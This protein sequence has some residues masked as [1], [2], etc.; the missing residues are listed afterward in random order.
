MKK[1]SI[2]LI[3]ITAF[4]ILFTINTNAAGILMNLETDTNNSENLVETE[5]NIVTN[6]ET[7][8]NNAS[9]QIVY[10]QNNS[11]DNFLSASNILSIII[12]VIGVL[13]ILLGI[14]LLIRFK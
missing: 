14:A 3:I 7:K 9:P 2:M 10:S 1:V 13:I 12:I 8:S 11:N 5:N 6:N 4:L